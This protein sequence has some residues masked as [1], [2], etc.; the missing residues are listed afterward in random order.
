MAKHLPPKY[1]PVESTNV[2]NWRLLYG[3]PQI[4]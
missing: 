4:G 1:T 3:A 2:H